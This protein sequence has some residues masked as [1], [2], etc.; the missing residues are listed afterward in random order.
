[1]ETSLSC[2]VAVNEQDSDQKTYAEI[3][4]SLLV[5]QTGEFFGK[6]IDGS[7]IVVRDVVGACL[8]TS[9]SLR[10]TITIDGEDVSDS[11]VG[12]IRIAHNLNYISTF[13]L[14]LGDPKYSPLTDS[15]IA[16]NSVVVITVF[17]NGQEIK[18]FTGLID[19]THTTYGGGYKLNIT[20]RDYGKKLLDKTMT[21]ISI[22]ESA[23]KAYRGSMVK[24]LASQADI[25]N[26][27]VPTGDAVTIDHSFQDQTIWDMI[28]KECAI[29]GW[30]VR[31]DENAVMQLKTRKLK[32]TADWEY[33]EDKFVQLGLETSD[34]GIINKVIILGA[35][36]EEEVITVE[37]DEIEQQ[38]EVPTE[39]YQE[40]T[41]TFNKSFAEGESVTAWSY[42]DTNFRITARYVGTWMSVGWSPYSQGYTHKPIG[43]KYAFTVTVLNADLIVRSETINIVDAQC[44]YHPELVYYIR[45]KYVD[46][47]NNDF[48]EKAFS[49]SITIKTKEL[50][51]G[52]SEWITENI[53]NETTVS[54]ITYT[55]VKA[56]VQ[57]NNSIALYGERKPNNEGTLPFPL[58]ETTDQC[59]RIGE[60]IIL[61]SH[62]FIKQ[63]DFLVNF[64]PKLIVGETVELTDKKI[65]YD[66]DKYFVEEVIHTI[67]INS[68]TGA[69]KPRTRIGCVY[70]A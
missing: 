19:N 21:L 39:E 46:Y 48:T 7:L 27:N 55:Q 15:H 67:S 54:T 40:D 34:E 35:I 26:I 56:T 63:P 31:H 5:N 1:M 42:E 14:S 25:T 49:I 18:M 10:M 57:D 23:E 6:T 11:I 29:E 58:A 66:G 24:Y 52:G 36:F 53:P 16:V 12:D 20:G 69:V 64:N 13:S 4:G 65:G 60:N 70:Y 68:K 22:Q 8:N 30:Y 51:A 33:G 47:E 38:V 2:F 59:K 44:Y 61:D 28:Q 43:A 32:T 62:R 9:Q 45:R 37:H 41:H 17:I 50:V 3:D